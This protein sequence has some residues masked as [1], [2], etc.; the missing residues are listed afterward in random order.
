MSEVSLARQILSRMVLDHVGDLN[1]AKFNAMAMEAEAEA[2]K[3]KEKHRRERQEAMEDEVYELL[4]FVFQMDESAQDEDD[5]R[6]SEA[7]AEACRILFERLTD[8]QRN[9]IQVQNRAKHS[10]GADSLER[11]TWTAERKRELDQSVKRGKSGIYGMRLRRRNGWKDPGNYAGKVCL[12]TRH[13]WNPIVMPGG[14]E[15]FLREQ[16]L[17]QKY[18]NQW[19]TN[20]KQAPFQRGDRFYVEWERLEDGTRSFV[21]IVSR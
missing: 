21:R 4:N 16:G 1:A 14:V 6:F 18:E 15:R 19:P 9:N 20:S 2:Q 3:I 17:W 11:T 13:G 12:I 5:L 7:R 10:P 8:D